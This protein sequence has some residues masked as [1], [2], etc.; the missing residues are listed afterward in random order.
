MTGYRVILAD[1]P[2]QFSAWSGGDSRT[3]DSQYRTMGTE[4]ICGLALQVNRWADPESVCF[5]WATCSGLPEALHVLRAWGYRFATVAFVWVKLGRA[6]LADKEWQYRLAASAEA[7]TERGLVT[8]R[9]Q[10]Y[11]THW[12][13]GHYTRSG[14]ELCLLGVRGRVPRGARDVPQVVH[15]P[16]R[17][18]SQKPDEVYQLIDRLYPDGP[19]L[20]MF[21]RAAWPGW[22]RWGDE[23][24][25]DDAG[26]ATDDTPT[27]C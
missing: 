12:G 11:G 8:Y 25:P 3:A 22:D 4:E 19:R 18:H 21:A 15:A 14:S 16:T 17:A 1:P 24:P 23:A 7:S 5:L 9:R 10:V 6:P 13:M 27:G 2:W 20:E 26:S